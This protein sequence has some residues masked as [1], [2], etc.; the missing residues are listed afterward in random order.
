VW[1]NGLGA[2]VDFVA[3]TSVFRLRHIALRYLGVGFGSLGLFG[4]RFVWG[5]TLGSAFCVVCCIGFPD[6]FL[7]K[8]F[9]FFFNLINDEKAIG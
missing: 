4:R 3:A 7:Y 1:G 5:A 2:G 9:N 8:P 6:C